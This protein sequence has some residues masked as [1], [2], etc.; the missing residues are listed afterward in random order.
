MVLVSRISWPVGIRIV[1]RDDLDDSAGFSNSMK[2]TDKSHYVR[3]M[4]N[5][6]AADNLIEG[7]IVKR[8]RKHSEIVNDVGIS[9]RIRVD[10]KRAWI[11]VLP[12]AYIQD[13][14]LAYSWKFS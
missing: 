14:L 1:W 6:V 7:I 8:I 13:F 11:L 5:H 12:A 3:N 2:L 10:S 4:F 9:S